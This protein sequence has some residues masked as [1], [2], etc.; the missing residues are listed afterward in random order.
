MS[1][2]GISQTTR[3]SEQAPSPGKKEKNTDTTRTPSAVSSYRVYRAE[4]LG[5]QNHIALFVETHQSGLG[6]GALYHV[7]GSIIQGMKYETKA[8]LAPEQ[9]GSYAGRKDYL[10]VVSVDDY[11]RFNTICQ[12][13]VPPGAQ[14]RLNGKKIDPSKPLY[15]CGEWNKDAT[16]ALRRHGVLK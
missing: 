16:D 1:S 15:R 8:A 3:P 4:Y 13:I 5:I 14:V 10:G 7:V 2:R 11:D 6:S 9:S 12:G